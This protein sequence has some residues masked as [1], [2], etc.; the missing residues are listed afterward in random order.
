MLDFEEQVIG[1]KEIYS[2]KFIK[3]KLEEVILPGGEK[4]QREIVEHPGSIAALPVTKDGKFIFIK[5]YRSAVKETIWEIPAGKLEPDEDPLTGLFREMKE[6]IG[7]TGGKCCKLC[8]FYPSPGVL[9]EQVHLY[10]YWGF[11]LG[12]PEPEDGENI[13]I[14][15]VSQLKAR[16]MIQ[17]GEIKDAKS[18]I[19]VHMAIEN[20]MS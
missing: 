4:K 1:S 16:K 19:A 12:E 14:V 10:L 2:G 13:K 7:A 8:Q 5:Q 17:T 15:K 9:N 6:E 3:L 20:R 18:I 11:E